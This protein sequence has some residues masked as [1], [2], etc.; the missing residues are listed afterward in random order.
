[1]KLFKLI[2]GIFLILA[3]VAA[4]I[5]VVESV[6]HGLPAEGAMKG[7]IRAWKPS[8]PYEGLAIILTGFFG[9]VSLLGGTMLSI[10]TLR[11]DFGVRTSFQK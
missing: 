6:K 10:L 7:C 9:A 8:Y 2:V 11:E 4:L 1:M 3:F 5:F